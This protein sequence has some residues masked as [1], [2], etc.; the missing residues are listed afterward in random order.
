MTRRG[1]GALVALVALGAT[2][3]CTGGSNRSAALPSPAAIVTDLYASLPPGQCRY[4]PDD[5]PTGG[6][7]PGRPPNPPTEHGVHTV[8]LTTNLGEIHMRV[9]ADN[10]PCSMGSFLH[11]VRAHFYDATPC[12]HLSKSSG[13][14]TCGDPTGTGIGG[15]GYT[16]AAEEPISDPFASAPVEDFPPGTAMLPE[17]FGQQDSRGST[18]S[19]CVLACPH[20]SPGQVAFATVTAGLPVL[21]A[22]FAAGTADRTGEGRPKRALALISV[23]LG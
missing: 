23:R 13:T 17:S 6:K 12:H 18:F 4:L 20:P 3:G 16:V 2:A 5:N 1:I 7:H 19:L 15:P 9:D 14:I 11:L 22:V 10:L 21:R 8:V